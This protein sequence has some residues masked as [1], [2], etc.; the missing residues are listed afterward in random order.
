MCEC[1]SLAVLSL[2]HVALCWNFVLRICIFAA[3]I[4]LSAAVVRKYSSV[5]ASE[6]RG[7]P[8]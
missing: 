8:I 7:A 5:V 6:V 1:R 3:F 2:D 4:T